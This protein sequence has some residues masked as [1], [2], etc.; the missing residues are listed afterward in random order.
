[1]AGYL[2]DTNHLGRWIDPRHPL[3]GRILAAIQRSDTFHIALPVITETIAG[4]SILPRAAQN[5]SEWQVL[6]PVLTLLPL[7]EADAVDAARLPVAL[8]RAGRQLGTVDAQIG[9]VALRY[10][11]TLLTTDRDFAA[12]PSLRLDSWL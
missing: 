7:D 11:L 4:F 6:R 1:M 10:N 3:R 8:R 9:T 12:V 5:W 2:L